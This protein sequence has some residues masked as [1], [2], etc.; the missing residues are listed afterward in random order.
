MY[1]IIVPTHT[2]VEVYFIVYNIVNTDYIRTVPD[3]QH[4]LMKLVIYFRFCE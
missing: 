2:Y 3:L 4:E 1:G